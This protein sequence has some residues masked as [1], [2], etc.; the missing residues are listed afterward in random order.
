MNENIIQQLYDGKIYPAENIGRGNAELQKANE[1]LAEE[2][3]KFI[4]SL[5]D[6]DRANFLKLNDLQDESAAL[7]GYESF[8]YG[9]KLAASHLIESS[10]DIE[11]IARKNDK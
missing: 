4:K 3:A 1:V 6:N 7:Y 8:A 9:F 2:K 10:G 5:S 11:G